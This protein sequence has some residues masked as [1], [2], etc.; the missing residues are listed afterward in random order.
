MPI[1]K[2][3]ADENRLTVCDA[4]KEDLEIYNGIKWQEVDER[5]EETKNIYKEET[6]AELVSAD[7]N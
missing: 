5:E 6:N 2:K 7:S 1:L 4:F 3:Q